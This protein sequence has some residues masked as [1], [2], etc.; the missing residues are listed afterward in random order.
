[1]GR[2]ER[3]RRPHR[4]ARPSWPA[5][6]PGKTT[7]VSSTSRIFAA[8]ALAAALSALPAHAAVPAGFGQLAGAG[9]ASGA[10]CSGPFELTGVSTVPGSWSFTVAYTGAATSICGAAGVPVA[11]GSWDPAVGGCVSG[12]TGLVCVGKVAVTGA[13]VVA[14]VQFCIPAMACYGGTATVVR[15]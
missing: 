14:T 11:T 8:A 10:G 12:S 4:E 15:L 6:G 13:P 3:S 5:V 1:M 2:P 9:T 7:D